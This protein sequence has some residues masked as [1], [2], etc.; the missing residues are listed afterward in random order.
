MEHPDTVNS[1][2]NLVS[3]YQDQGRWKEAE[4]LEMEMVEMRQ[5]VLGEEHCQKGLENN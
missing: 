1:I 4:K 5:S 2:R 3:I